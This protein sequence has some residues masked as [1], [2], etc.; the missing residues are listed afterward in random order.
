MADGLH[1]IHPHRHGPVRVYGSLLTAVL[2]AGNI[3]PVKSK[4]DAS[5][6]AHTIIIENMRFNPEALTVKRGARIVWINRDL[7]P[8]TATA[9][10]KTFDSGSIATSASWVYVAR[11]PGHYS[12]GCTFHPTMK[13]TLTV[14]P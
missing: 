3:G 10:A 8:H 6:G 2:I 12:F 11:K 14:E 13:G 5:A 1:A 7:F 4:V 9:D